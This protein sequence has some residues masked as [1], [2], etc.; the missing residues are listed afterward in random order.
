MAD[1]TGL[2]APEDPTMRTSTG[3]VA[4]TE[5]TSRLHSCVS[6][7]VPTVYDFP[8]L[9][10][11]QP[12]TRSIPSLSRPVV[13]RTTRQT[14]VSGKTSENNVMLRASSTR[15]MPPVLLRYWTTP[16]FLWAVDHRIS[17]EPKPMPYAMTLCS[18]VSSSSLFSLTL[19]IFSDASLPLF[20]GL[21]VV[22]YAK[23]PRSSFIIE[24]QYVSRATGWL[25]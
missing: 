12:I 22:S 3:R 10:P 19:F 14:L 6:S 7:D 5:S 21:Q 2:E 17:C 13:P 20:V 15:T 8:I 9:I 25:G 24:W 4:Q 23:S 16:H 18:D 1:R 11:P